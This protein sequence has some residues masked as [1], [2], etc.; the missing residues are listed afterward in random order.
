MNQP[1]EN[2]I[3][4]EK[5]ILPRWLP[6]AGAMALILA[7][8]AISV[9]TITQLRNATYWRRHAF[10]VI[11]MAQAFQNNFLDIQR[12][13][14]GYVVMGTHGFLTS[15]QSCTNLEQKQFAQL[16]QLV[17][18][19]PSQQLRLKIV[20]NAVSNVVDFDNLLIA[21]YNYSGPEGVLR[22]DESG[23][24]RVLSDDV[25]NSLKAFGDNE[26][27][28]L[29]N[30]DIEEQ[31]TSHTLEEMLVISS[32]VAA[33]LLLLSNF[34][35]T[36]ELNHRR[37]A[38]AKLNEVKMLQEAIISS[39]NYAIVTTDRNGIIQT[40][41]PAAERILGYSPQ[42]VIGKATPMIWRDAKEISER[43]EILSGRLGHPIRPTF[44]TI[45]AKIEL[46]QL[47]QGEWTFVRKGGARFP[48]SAV[49]SP[50]TDAAGNLTG[51]LGFFR[52]ISDRKKYELDREKLV[53]ELRD[54]LAQVKT[55]SGL[56]P[57]CGWCK[58]VRSDTG[59][60]QTV[61]QYVHLHTDAT[62]THGICPTCREKFK[63][64]IESSG[65]QA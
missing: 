47:D 26:Q 41:N 23:K 58:K 35:T 32:L 8:A 25:F 13:A 4:R 17:Q 50:L 14:N 30:R 52:D 33:A 57:I 56:I 53:L 60:W 49:L 19:D 22:M 3:P 24:D 45:M 34:L 7:V 39:A 11:V 65:Q 29:D 40:F 36:R 27:K 61:E 2:P 15:Y 55:L 31:Q 6:M 16:S 38:E 48:A 5:I 54:A 20:E 63:A 64:E 21:T 28:L 51:Y 62:F 37:R 1:P 59:Y 44:E 9:T 10:E 18:D 46:D 12:A 42:E 43:A